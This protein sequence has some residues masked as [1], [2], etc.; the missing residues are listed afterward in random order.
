MT[1][2]TPSRDDQD[3]SCHDNP[4][5][6][7][8]R[9]YLTPLSAAPGI[10]YVTRGSASMNKLCRR[11]V[12]P[13]AALIFLLSLLLTVCPYI[14]G[15]IPDISGPW[16]V[17]QDVYLTLTIEGE[18][19]TEH[20]VARDVIT[21]TQTGNIVRYYLDAQDPVT[22]EIHRLERVGTIEGNTVTFTG[23]AVVPTS[24]FTFSRN[25]FVVV[26]TIQ[27]NRIDANVTVDVAFTYMGFSGTITG[28]GTVVFI[29][30]KPQPAPIITSV[31]P[32]TGLQGASISNFTVNG[33]NLTATST[34]AFSGS[35]IT[36]G[37]YTLRSATQIVAGISIAAGATPG[38]RSVTVWNPDGQSA[39]L[40]SAFNVEST[41]TAP[42]ISGH[43]VSTTVDSGGTVTLKITATGTA[44]LTYQ[45]YE[46][47]QGDT[48]KP[49]G[50]N[51]PQF[52]S[53][54]LLRSTW[55]WVR[56]RNS[57]GQADSQAAVV[58]VRPPSVTQAA[59]ALA[60]G[61]TASTSTRGPAGEM[62]AGYAVA[63]VSSGSA[64]Y[65]T[66]VFSYRQNGVVVSEVGVPSSPPTLAARF[67]V[68]SR[69]KVI[70]ASGSGT[71]DV[72]TGFAAV[73]PNS[74]AASLN[75]RLRN[76]NGVTLAQGVVTL[77]QGE[78]IAKFLDQ[79]APEFVLP[80]G[81]ITNGLGSLEITSD[82][83]VSIL[84][85][86]LT[87]N[88]R[89]DLL[90]TSTPI[91]DLSKPAPTG[92]L[93][94]PQIAD[95]GGYRTTLILMNTSGSVETGVVRFYGN[96]GSALAVR[97][98]D[99][100]T[101]DTRFPYSI[102]AGG[103]LRLVTDGSPSNVNVGWAQLTP[104]SGMNAP[105]SAAIFSLTQ[106]GTLVTESGVP[107]V[108]STTHAR[109]YV[110][111]SGG[112]DTGLAV[113]NPG[114]S[115]MRITAMAYQLDGVTRA[116][117]SQALVDLAPLGHE[118]KFAGEL[119][120]YLPPGFTGLLDLSSSVP[121][122]ALTLRSL[123][124]TRGDFLITTFPI[125]DLNQS[126][127]VP[128]IFPQVADG[129]GYQT[130][131]ILLSTSTAASTVMVNYIGNNGSPVSIGRLTPSAT[132]GVAAGLVSTCA[133]VAGG[134]IRCWGENSYGQLG[135]VTMTSRSTPVAVLGLT[136]GVSAIAAGH[137]HFCALLWHGGVKCWG[138]NTYGQLGNRWSGPTGTP[139]EVAGL[140][141]VTSIA[142]GYSHTCALLDGGGVKCWGGNGNG[143]LG[144]GTKTNRS[145]PVNVMGLTSG[146]TAIST[147]N[148]HTCALMA[149]G[150][151]KCWGDNSSGQLGDGTLISRST[152]VN[153]AGLTS[154]VVGVS[155]GSAH[156]CAL[157]SGG[158]VKCWGLNGRSQLGDGTQ[159]NRS[160]PVN[161][162]GL[163]SGALAV[164]AGNAHTCAVVAG[165]GVKCWG[166]NA[167]GQL[168]NN[169]TA[170]SGTPVQ[171]A[172]L[173]SGLKAI[174]AGGSHSCALAP[175]GQ[176]KCWGRNVSGQ[177]G[178]GT[179]TSRST[180]V[181]V[182]GLTGK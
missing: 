93:S 99:G 160:I 174:A 122:A 70:P 113:A 112:H 182:I 28:Y 135:D 52:T 79:L 91:A 19:E 17:T 137:Y 144:D 8:R 158:G 165:G 154:G 77:T 108:A 106:S 75:L 88:Q 92:I 86:R 71:V 60:A 29:S 152:P 121:F 2:R 48:A 3:R 74:T 128:M 38:K 133:L 102:P 103:F 90:L 126:P 15:A 30:N 119:V 9:R 14:S 35:G 142:A 105:V 72:L 170:G 45:W 20:Q 111:M 1:H 42:V 64:P 46:G 123:T 33:S 132:D 147:G 156:T 32:T 78:H 87:I 82:K 131:I 10:G 31:S 138:D 118:A 136:E 62:T 107:A 61:G 89:G 50:T 39:N 178:D 167:D 47:V 148:G 139:L 129:G 55:H 23:I 100:S 155:T 96:N 110:D 116:G 157:L 54:P 36:V 68:D 59:L 4:I 84:A 149:G 26:G 81:F 169:S 25:S 40:A 161:V 56:V 58:S 65:G 63:T 80:S 13:T 41:C 85:L 117:S 166:D 6:P 151:V 162:S 16:S 146:V 124:N 22:G 181:D 44:P 153:V 5:P 179:T 168:G 18:S 67:F 7:L 114:N 43:P 127:P 171:V 69:A 11:A 143:Q 95:G 66:A 130:Q 73:N 109:I 37:Y 34:L 104:D 159:T 21:L 53:Q 120:P 101:A 173:T 12:H 145:T 115:S 98:I 176:V 175:A 83:P 180:P 164:S 134:G 94:F 125:A 163:S 51:S 97:M 141:S 140:R 49:V 27:D 177:L 150:G 57:C 172:G 24:G 76:G